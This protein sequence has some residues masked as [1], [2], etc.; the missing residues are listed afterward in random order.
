MTKA[1]WKKVGHRTL[2]FMGDGPK[3]IVRF[4]VAGP[5][6]KLL[7]GELEAGGV[8]ITDELL[9]EAVVEWERLKA[10]E[11]VVKKT[12]SVGS[13]RNFMRAYKTARRLAE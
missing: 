10:L 6:P 13:F 8:T 9:R 4:G 1:R 7:D 12:N 11:P 2:K 5:K 3:L